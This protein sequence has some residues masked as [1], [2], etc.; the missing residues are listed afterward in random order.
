MI[1]YQA[2][3]PDGYTVKWRN[4]TWAEYRRIE[5]SYLGASSRFSYPMGAYLDVYK[6]V[7]LDGPLPQFV[8][9]GIVAYVAIQQLS[10]NPFNGT[11]DDIK[12]QLYLSRQR[13]ESSYLETAKCL[14]AAAF[15]YRFEEMEDWDP[16]TFFDMLARAEKVLG[17]LAEPNNPN[18]VKAPSIPE[19]VKREALHRNRRKK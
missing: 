3:W 16:I 4:L 1:I 6:L 8:P 15:K 17:R 14:I 11:Y 19:D 7:M 13:L 10:T 2:T 18:E 5:P 12:G 9:A